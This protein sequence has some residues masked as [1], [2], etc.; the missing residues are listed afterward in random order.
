MFLRLVEQ[1]FPRLPLCSQSNKWRVGGHKSGAS[2][3]VKVMRGE[4]G[5]IDDACRRACEDIGTR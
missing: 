4:S 5:G 3:D 1:L 2:V